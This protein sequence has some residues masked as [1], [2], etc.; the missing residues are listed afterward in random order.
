MTCKYCGK[1]GV[2][3]HVRL[4]NRCDEC[5]RR[6][7][8]YTWYNKR[9]KHIEANDDKYPHGYQRRSSTVGITNSGRPRKRRYSK[10][11]DVNELPEGF[12]SIID[13]YKRLQAQGYPVPKD[14]R[15]GRL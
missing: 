10:D 7:E 3:P 13:T 8:T 14:I 2:R 6:Y 4:T 11:T 12:V 15:E 5:G 9:R 1:S